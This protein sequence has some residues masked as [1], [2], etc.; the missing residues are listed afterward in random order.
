MKGYKLIA[1]LALLLPVFSGTARAQDDVVELP[2]TTSAYIRDYE[3]FRLAA[4][5]AGTTQTEVVKTEEAKPVASAQPEFKEPVFTASKVHQYLGIATMAAA[6]ATFV[7]HFHPCQG[8][9]CGPQP[10]R[11]ING[12]HATLGKATA[13]LA[14]ATVASGLYA[15]WDDFHK[16]DGA[17]DPDNLHVI[18]GVAGAAAMIYA[19]N[20]SA[21]STTT[22]TSHAALAELGALSMAV[23]IKLTW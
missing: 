15:H 11:D 14:A 8:A 17:T 19:I 13:V 2:G 9:G 12:T 4:N 22:P 7:T 20:K 23:A 1:G 10:P 21:N 18:L 6:A 16:E 5:D 3:S